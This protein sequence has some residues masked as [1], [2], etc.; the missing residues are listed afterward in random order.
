[1]NQMRISGFHVADLSRGLTGFRP[2][3]GVERYIS[4]FCVEEA[5]PLDVL[6]LDVHVFRFDVR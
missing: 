6:K 3:L 2:L 5:D 1:M 4:E